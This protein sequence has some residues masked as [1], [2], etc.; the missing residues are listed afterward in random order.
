MK[1]RA[2]L[3]V[4]FFFLAIVPLVSI[5]LYS[6]YSSI[7]AFRSAVEA[8]SWEVADGMNQRMAA[9]RS[10]LDHFLGKATE[11]R[12]ASMKDGE[13]G[14]F[15]EMAAL[16]VETAELAT[17]V[18]ACEFIPAP[19]DELVVSNPEE[20][21]ESH[22]PAAVPPHPPE[23]FVF[24]TTWLQP[25]QRAE[26]TS[27]R[28]HQEE[29]HRAS[30][31]Q[32][33]QRHE[34]EDGQDESTSGEGEWVE[35]LI[36]EGSKLMAMA[37]ED[38]EEFEK[39]LEH[40]FSEHGEEIATTAVSFVFD[41]GADLVTQVIEDPEQLE[42]VLVARGLQLQDRLLEA[43]PE[44]LRLTEDEL[45][46]LE[47]RR[48]SSEAL[49]GRGYTYE[50]HEGEHLVGHMRA[51]VSA[52]EVLEAVLDAARRDEGEIPFAVD[53]SGEI[54]TLDPAHREIVNELEIVRDGEV[55]PTH[56]T[57][58]WIVVQTEDPESGTAFGIARP[59][60]DALAEI[61]T[62]AVRNMGFGMVLV[63]VAGF[64]ILPL[65]R[66]MTRHLASLTGAAEALARGELTTRVPVRSRD[67]F[68]ALAR[69]FNQM[70]KDLNENQGRLLEEERLRREQE[71]ETRLLELEN[72]R[73]SQDLEDARKF[74]LSLLPDR[75]PNDPRYDIAVSMQTA[76]EV[77]G[78]YY[79]FLS[80]TDG[81]LT[82]ALGDATGHGVAAGTMVTAAK[83]LFTA[84][85]DRE[86][87]DF[88][89]RAA[90]VIRTM[91]LGRMSMALGVVRLDDDG[92]TAAVAGMPPLLVHRPDSNTV[93]EIVIPGMPLGSFHATE[94]N[95]VRIPLGGGDTV[96]LMSD[97]FPELLNP[98]GDPLGYDRARDLFAETAQAS[99]QEII[100]AL[101]QQ[102]LSYRG[103]R[104][105]A[106]DITFVV[107]RKREMI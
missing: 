27:T 75:L 5:V 64:G 107:L 44:R 22:E 74:Q 89:R 81:A 36:R 43:V 23:R 14:T 7:G 17:L 3:I 34:D 61:R 49:L 35:E 76:T 52:S 68:G 13:V 60:G 104:A 72:N 70:A 82:V 53:K 93:E 47:K 84:A 28:E 32:E 12:V 79:D 33:E 6:Y 10:D 20:L 85:G 40:F 96:L 1:L 24:H 15:E 11:M 66:R 73:K 62:T 105:Q 50:I 37:N 101:E 25:E 19:P 106:D 100:N 77:G 87:G 94:Y 99:P 69:A 91:R 48:A 26:S 51:Q 42:Q 71:V 39:E 65:S 55:A 67:E 4:A 78:D 38:P 92:L 88:L 90:D 95:E 86:P 41:E 63:A 98:D 2:K 59:V 54:Y 18:E 58:D 9:V 46:E 57:G 21:P 80:N 83:S 30:T 31:R 103:A 29:R 56:S 45:V 16:D 8:E 102:A 97:G